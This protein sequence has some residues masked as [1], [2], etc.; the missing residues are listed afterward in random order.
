[1]AQNLDRQLHALYYMLGPMGPDGE[2]QWGLPVLMWGPPGVGKTSRAREFAARWGLLYTEHSPALEG[3][4]GFGLVPVPEGIGVDQ[5]LRFPPRD[6]V[7]A[8]S[9]A[10]RALVCLDEISQAGPALQAPLLGLVQSGMIGD[11]YLGPRT[12]R[13]ATANP[14]NQGGQW[15][16]SAP[17]AN[18]FVHM[19]LDAPDI[20]EW[21][22]GL[23]T[24]WRRSSAG[25]ILDPEA[26]EARVEQAWPAPWSK[27]CALVG[28]LMLRRP[29]LLHKLP[30]EGDLQASL[31]WP[32][33]RSWEY[34]T[35][36]W[37]AAEVHGLSET[38]R[39][40][41]VTGCVGSGPANELAAYAADLDLPNPEALL[42]GVPWQPDFRLDRTAAVLSSV[43]SLIGGKDTTARIGR[44]WTL[45]GLSPD[46]DTAV[47][48]ATTMC[49]AGHAQHTAARPV[50][51]KL[52][53]ALRAAGVL[54]V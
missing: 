5:V 48:A 26:E 42:S 54:G 28:A 30:P 38:D 1:M 3:E 33:P 17:L 32:S 29:E 4:A 37:T 7:L 25:S 45:I 8:C 52:S 49:M 12:R 47:P 41:L 13:W 43:A 21:A 40:V 27:A 31:A 9:R 46:A 44:A 11:A 10:S 2:S 35:R 19:Q 53:P 39:D 34:A 23:A 22:A 24:G 15:D 18:R 14:V 6:W 50:L 51:A 20:R 36:C 16:A